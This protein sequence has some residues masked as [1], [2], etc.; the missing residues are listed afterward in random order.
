MK[1]LIILMS[2]LLT[3]SLGVMTV[4]AGTSVVPS[5]LSPTQNQ[6]TVSADTEP[7][8]TT[9]ALEQKT[10]TDI[11]ADP[12]R[13]EAAIQAFEGLQ[14]Q[15]DELNRRSTGAERMWLQKE[16]S[17][18]MPLIKI[19]HEHI[20]AEL[21]LIRKLAVEEG[22]KKT[23]AAIDGLLLNK[24]QRLDKLIEKFQEERRESK[25]GRDIRGRQHPRQEMQQDRRTRVRQPEG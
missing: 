25:R 3:V 18:R 10:E 12:N 9:T 16:S 22:A 1:R 19:N 6:P 13:I 14:K 7:N 11:L 4:L 5:Q 20:V 8:K 15:L 2:I 21:M 24:Q 17:N 23:T